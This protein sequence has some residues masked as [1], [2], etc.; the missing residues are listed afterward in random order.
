M[1]R[2]RAEL[3]VGAAFAAWSG[4]HDP[5][6]TAHKGQTVSAR[7]R[8]IDC[9]RKH[10][11]A[12]VIVPKEEQRAQTGQLRGLDAYVAS[13]ARMGAAEFSYADR[14]R[15]TRREQPAISAQ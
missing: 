4:W 3:C 6:M 5:A 9:R 11:P 15:G 8:P 10:A 2:S 7:L 12:A 1:L 13:L 14:C